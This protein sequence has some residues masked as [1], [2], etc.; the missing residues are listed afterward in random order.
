VALDQGSRAAE[1][2]VR[3]A[4]VAVAAA[5]AV[6]AV[7]QLGRVSWSAG[8]ER[9][10]ADIAAGAC[11]KIVYARRTEVELEGPVDAAGLLG[12]LDSRHP[13][14]YR[15]A[16]RRGDAL[17][18]GASP[19]RLVA[20][21]GDRVATEAMA[22]S[23]PAGG[24]GGGGAAR[25]LLESRKDRGEQ[26]VVSRAIA[27][28]LAPLVDSLELAAVPEVREL[29][30]VVHLCTPV[31]GRLDRPRH[32][33]ELAAALH[34][35]PAVGGEPSKRALAWIA[36]HEEAPRGWY[37]GA[38]GWVDAAGDGELAVA[39]RS[40]L[41]RGARVYLWAGAGIVAESDPDAEY[42]ETGLKQRALLDV[43]GA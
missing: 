13:D 5:P 11:E 4:A 19:E 2:L 8:V 38:V 32:L 39:I 29:R 25:A 27:R 35:T 18:A 33:L 24:R 9:I 40:G 16:F 22:G 14:C 23:I 30:D 7:H 34:P 10:R 6:R 36:R 43:L 1:R 20:L 3:Q 12:R 42:E 28:A 31:R 37:A 17:F 21:A 41:V 15:F 26:A